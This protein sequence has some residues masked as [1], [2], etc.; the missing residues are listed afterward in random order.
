[1]LTVSLYVLRGL[2]SSQ[3]CHLIC[4]RLIVVSVAATGSTYGTSGDN[5][6]TL[7]KRCSHF[8]NLSIE[9]YY[10][11]LQKHKQTPNNHTQTEWSE[12]EDLQ[13]YEEEVK[14]KK[15]TAVKVEPTIDNDA[16]YDQGHEATYDNDDWTVD[17]SV[18]TPLRPRFVGQPAP[19]PPLALKNPAP[20]PT[21][22]FRP[23]ALSTPNTIPKP[24]DIVRIHRSP[25]RKMS[26][27]P[28]KSIV[29]ED[30]HPPLGTAENPYIVYLNLHCPEANGPFEVFVMKGLEYNSMDRT[31]YMIRLSVHPNDSK[32]YTAKVNMTDDDF[33][34]KSVHVTG[35]WRDSWHKDSDQFLEMVDEDF[36]QA[37]QKALKKAAAKSTSSNYGNKHWELIFPDGVVLDNTVFRPGNNT[38]IAKEKALMHQVAG[39]DEKG[40]DIVLYGM[41]LHWWIAEKNGAEEMGHDAEEEELASLLKR[42][43]RITK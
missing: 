41:F 19:R 42:K 33:K 27:T 30:T 20:P 26:S 2:L 17:E 13:A 21:S 4:L 7:Q 18:Q 23:I 10:A 37:C 8:T 25:A 24:A 35:P 12:Y 36:H 5:F 32:L 39:K 31:V 16:T 6:R 14:E 11:L 29:S 1:M 9:K 34:E 43:A 3:M 28:F 40:K 15:A 38:L 22:D